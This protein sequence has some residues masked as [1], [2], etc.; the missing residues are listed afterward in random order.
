M[1]EAVEKAIWIGYTIVETPAEGIVGLAMK[2]FLVYLHDRGRAPPDR[3]GNDPCT[4]W[5]AEPDG[6]IN[7][8]LALSAIR[9]VARLVPELAPLCA[10]ALV[11][12]EAS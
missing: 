8:E 12:E 11:A 2:T 5:D 7:G 6:G 3:R 1:G 10:R 9:D 4:L